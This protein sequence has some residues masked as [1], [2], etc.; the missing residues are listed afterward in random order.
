MNRNFLKPWVLPNHVRKLKT[1]Q[2]RH[3]H[4]HQDDSNVHLQQAIQRFTLPEDAVSRFSPSSPRIDL[5]GQ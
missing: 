5:I 4:V 1:I 3:A 2:L